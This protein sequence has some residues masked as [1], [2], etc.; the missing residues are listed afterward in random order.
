MKIQEDIL[1][2]CVICPRRCGSNRRQGE[3]GACGETDEIRLAR[4]AL[5]MWEEPCISGKSGSG[6]IFF[7]GCPLHCVFCQNETIANG[8]QGKAVSD[9]R[10]TEI[11]LELQE[12]GANNINLV[13]PDHYAPK[14]IPIIESAK[15]QGLILPI[16]YNTS[17][18]IKTDI[19]R[20]LEGIVDIYLPDFKYYNRQLAGNYAKAPDYPEVAKAA[21]NEMVRQT[22]KPV[23]R[24]KG[25]KKF[26]SSRAYNQWEGEEE[27]LLYR[28]TIVRHLLLPGQTE[29][30]KCIIDYLLKTYGTEIYISI[31]N[32]YTPM[33]HN[34]KYP[35]LHRRVS[36]AEYEEV[37]N[38]ALKG[39]IENGFLQEGDTASESFIPKFDYEGV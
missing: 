10:L 22:G 17:S 35:E 21:I 23:F 34:S 2:N 8:T 32:Q 38:F 4:A 39:G 30:S 36:E 26:L 29:D 15:R 5:H 37:I 7:T 11:L 13:T 20:S 18:Y 33:H 6:A 12:Q 31:M 14:L 3:R 9:E 16:V 19:L 1:E 25:R 27:V 24:M 28:G